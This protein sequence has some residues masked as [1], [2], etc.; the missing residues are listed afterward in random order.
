MA[1]IK[2]SCRHS[3]HGAEY[4]GEHV[5]LY[6]CVFICLR[7]Y[8]RNCLSSLYQN[9]CTCYLWP[10]LGRGTTRSLASTTHALSHAPDDVS[11]CCRSHDANRLRG[12]AENRSP[13]FHSS[14]IPRHQKRKTYRVFGLALTAVGRSQLL[15]RWPGTHCRI[16]SGIH[17]AAQTVLGVYLKRTCSRV[18]STSSALGVLNDYALYKSTHS[19]THSLTHQNQA[20]KTRLELEVDGK[21][22]EECSRPN[23]RTHAQTDGPSENIVPP[24]IFIVT[25][26]LAKKTKSH[27]IQQ[28]EWKQN[29]RTDTTD[30]STLLV[31][32]V[33]KHGDKI[34]HRQLSSFRTL[35][36]CAAPRYRHNTVVFV[37]HESFVSDRHTFLFGSCRLGCRLAWVQKPLY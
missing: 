5:C 31:N 19:P 7:T 36:C 3:V 35:L 26:I 30:R 25:H 8:L 6:V 37:V 15:A 32:V 20:Q 21:P 24:A 10:W 2:H 1:T 13:N 28:L 29:G 11:C 12:V 4:C 22:V 16:L 9:F 33:D 34:R 23:A 17:L 18:T 27:S 14:L